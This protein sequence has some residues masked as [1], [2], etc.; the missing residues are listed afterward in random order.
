MFNERDKDIPVMYKS[1]NDKRQH[2]L[3]EV[4]KREQK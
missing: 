3:Q 1:N 4:R 2:D